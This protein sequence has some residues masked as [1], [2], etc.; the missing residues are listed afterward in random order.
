M[1]ARRSGANCKGKIWSAPPFWFFISQAFVGGAL[2]S[3]E[4]D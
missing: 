2:A 3:S 4:L 1:N